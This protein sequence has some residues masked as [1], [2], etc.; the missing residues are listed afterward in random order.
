MMTSEFGLG[1]SRGGR[2]GEVATDADPSA[3]AHGQPGFF[4]FWRRL[5]G[6]Y[7]PEKRYMRG[8]DTLSVS[9]QA[10]RD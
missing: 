2:R 5:F 4:G 10:L 6:R 8:S 7:R 3:P 1:K 9:E